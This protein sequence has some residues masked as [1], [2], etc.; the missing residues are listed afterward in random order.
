[1]NSHEMDNIGS[2]SR[3][4]IDSVRISISLRKTKTLLDMTM[5]VAV[6]NRASRKSKGNFVFFVAAQCVENIRARS[7]PS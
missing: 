7:H 2:F 1:M 5:I 6:A 4:G 3:R